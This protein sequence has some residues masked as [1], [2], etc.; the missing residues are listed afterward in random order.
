[1]AEMLRKGAKML[2][3]ACP[4][5]GSPLFQMQSGELY[6]P[7]DKREVKILKDGEDEK[8]VTLQ[9]SLEKTINNKVELIGA[10][11]E[12]ETDPTKIKELVETLNMLLI[13]L[14]NIKTETRKNQ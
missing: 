6:C 10:K 1:M 11:L 4:E 12:A 13:A 14:K 2:S 5:C 3:L 8:K 7:K 9:T